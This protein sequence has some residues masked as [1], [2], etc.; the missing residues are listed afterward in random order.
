MYVMQIIKC[1]AIVDANNKVT[2]VENRNIDFA[3]LKLLHGD[4]ITDTK[5]EAEEVSVISAYLLNNAPGFEVCVC[6]CWV[7][8]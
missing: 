3:R 2:E 7:Y 5:L 6:G 4:K 8:V 1:D